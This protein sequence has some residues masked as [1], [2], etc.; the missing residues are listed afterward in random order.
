MR[1]PHKENDRRALGS[2]AGLIQYLVHRPWSGATKARITHA[3]ARLNGGGDDVAA[4]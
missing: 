1:G 4:D 3:V 2:C